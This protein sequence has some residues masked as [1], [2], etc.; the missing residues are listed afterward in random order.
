MRKSD[1]TAGFLLGGL[2]GAGMIL[3]YTPESGKSVRGQAS[4]FFKNI[5]REVK[6][7]AAERRQQLE[8]ELE[9]LRTPH[10]SGGEQA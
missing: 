7:A 2:I 3:L 10:K 9:A 1:F 8:A 6:L 4:G 5:G